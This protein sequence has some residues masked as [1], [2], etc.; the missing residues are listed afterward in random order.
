MQLLF[1]KHAL[2]PVVNHA[3]KTGGPESH[4]KRT[5]FTLNYP[6]VCLPKLYRLCA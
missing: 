5:F 4:G 2:A 3:G 1:F 6:L